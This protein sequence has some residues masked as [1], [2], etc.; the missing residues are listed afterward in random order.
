LA[1]SAESDTAFQDIIDELKQEEA[2]SGADGSFWFTSAE[3]Q[4]NVINCIAG[5]YMGGGAKRGRVY[6]WLP[7]HLADAVGE[8]SPRTFLTAWKVAADHQ[9]AP[10]D[11]AVDHL[12]L[13]EGVR[14]ASG[15]RLS[16]LRQDYP[17]IPLVL[18]PLDGESVP[19]PWTHLEEIWRDAQT[20]QKIGSLGPQQ[21]PLALQGSSS[22]ESAEAKLLHT[23]RTIGVVEIR[24]NEKINVPDIFRVE[25]RIKRRGGVKPPR[26]RPSI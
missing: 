3:L 1:S 15:D 23:L 2:L 8:T 16:E 20:V 10:N 22:S 14:Q 21:Q 19:M 12:G 24:S 25:A 6:T 17:W 26:G 4:R 18:E 13:S 11:R 9:P 7:T 5:E